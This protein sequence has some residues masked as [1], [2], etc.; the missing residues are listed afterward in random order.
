[1]KANKIAITAALMAL[2]TVCGTAKAYERPQNELSVTYGYVTIPQFAETIGAV[3][4][5]AF[6]L[7]YWQISNMH[8]YGALGAEY[9]Y[10]L[11]KTF[12]V[13]GVALLDITRGDA[14]HK[15]KDGEPDTNL[16]KYNFTFISLMPAVKATWFD[17]AKGG[18]Y[19]K[20]AFGA[21]LA[22]LPQSSVSANVAFQISPVCGEFGGENTRGFVE[23]GLGMQGLISGG[24]RCRF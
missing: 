18:M 12:S 22:V 10:S 15:G 20:L 13:G 8:M 11:N 23:L 7:G 1:M 3:F 2:L 14:I 9:F 19:S 24:V 6:S 5:T 21:S 16:G 4:G 17:R